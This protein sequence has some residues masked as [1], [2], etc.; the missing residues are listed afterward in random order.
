LTTA[1]GHVAFTDEDSVAHSLMTHKQQ[2]MN[3]ITGGSSSSSTVSRHSSGS[4]LLRMFGSSKKKEPATA[5]GVAAAAAAAAAPA[6]S[7]D[8]SLKAEWDAAP[9]IEGEWA[10]K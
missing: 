2:H 1:S 8:V 5:A 3:S 10:V 9:N 7:S 6:G 4:S